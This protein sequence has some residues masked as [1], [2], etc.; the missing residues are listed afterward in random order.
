MLETLLE[1]A[2][3]WLDATGP[4]AAVVVNA[5]G[6]LSRNLAEFPFPQRCNESDL[7]TVEQRVLEALQ[8]AG[9]MDEGRYY[10]LADLTPQEVG[11]LAERQLFHHGGADGFAGRGVFVHRDQSLS[12]Q[13]NDVDHIRIRA[14]TS[15]MQLEQA[16]ERLNAVDDQLEQGLDYAFDDRLGYLTASL[17]LVGT[18][19]Q[20]SLLL[21][22]PGITM[23][24]GLR[25]LE[26]QLLSKRHELH[27][28]LGPLHE[29]RGDLLE[30]GNAVTLGR[31]EEEILYHVKQLAQEA[32]DEEKRSRELVMSE[33]GHGIDD[34]IGRA[35]GIARG[36]RMLDLDE[37]M[38][39]WSSLRLGLA[40]GLADGYT[41]KQLNELLVAALPAHLEMRT[42]KSG[43]ER[44]LNME[45]AHQFRVSFS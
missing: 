21:H 13:V 38:G 26:E 12:V 19:F 44:S 9:V 17:A 2:P 31:S 10:P 22:L 23:A 32:L 6:T 42:E 28:M 43:D 37:A 11:V 36:A 29:A 15:G 18:G 33:S 45:R 1:T 25:Q 40:S 27:G 39:L 16:W 14:L 3:D 24:G 8:D 5:R 30:L 35:L 20:A 7:Q 34:R 4:D 41:M